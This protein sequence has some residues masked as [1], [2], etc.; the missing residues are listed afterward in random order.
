MVGDQGRAGGVPARVNLGLVHD[1][2]GGGAL[3]F[4][5]VGEVQVCTLVLRLVGFWF[6]LG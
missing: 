6:W 4:Y 2:E 3:S 5:Q 1:L